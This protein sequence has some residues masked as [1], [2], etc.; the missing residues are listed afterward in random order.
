M[1]LRFRF[2][3]TRGCGSAARRSPLPVGGEKL[4]GACLTVRSLAGRHQSVGSS[5]P[6]TET[7]FERR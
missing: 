7:K 5:I 3:V 1:V 4:V 6:P 2:A